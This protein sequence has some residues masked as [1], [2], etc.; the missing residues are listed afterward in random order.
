MYTLRWYRRAFTR[1][2]ASNKCGCGKHAII[3]QNASIFARWRWR[4]LH[5]FKQVVNLYSRRIGAIFGM[6][7][8]HA[9]LSASAGLSCLLYFNP[10]TTPTVI[11]DIRVLWRSGLSVQGWAS[12]CPDVK[13]YKWLLNPVWHRMPY[14]CTHNGNSGRQTVKDHRH[15]CG[16]EGA[17]S[18]PGAVYSR[19]R[20]LQSSRGST[21]NLP[22]NLH[23]E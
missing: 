11:F 16:Q 1:Y 12:K 19:A 5:Y 8:R 20:G 14:S 9:G 21:P 10:L 23:P 2:G 13:N 7:S 18:A 17:M 3:E 6:L 22:I 15:I 4:L